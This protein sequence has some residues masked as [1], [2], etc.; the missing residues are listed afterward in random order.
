[1]QGTEFFSRLFLTPI[2]PYVE[3][4]PIY[5]HPS[6][7]LQSYTPVSDCTL[8]NAASS[9]NS[10]YSNKK[11]N[12]SLMY[13]N[14]IP[15]SILD[16]DFQCFAGSSNDTPLHLPALDVSEPDLID[17]LA[18]SIAQERTPW[19]QTFQQTCHFKT[20]Q[21]STNLSL[22]SN[23]TPSTSPDIGPSVQDS[24][25]ASRKKSKK[26]EKPVS[27]RQ[28]SASVERDPL[29]NSRPRRYSCIHV[30]CGMEFLSSGHLVRHHRIHTQER[31]FKCSIP[32]CEMTF[33]RS[34][35]AIKHSR[36]HVKK[37]QIAG[38]EIPPELLS[39]RV[40]FSAAALT[41]GASTESYQQRQYRRRK[42]T[43]GSSQ[44][45]TEPS[46]VISASTSVSDQSP[47]TCTDEIR[48][49]PS[50]FPRQDLSS[51]S[52]TSLKTP[53]RCFPMIGSSS[54]HAFTPDNLS[55]SDLQL[56][57]VH[58]QQLSDSAAMW[59]Y[60]NNFSAPPAHLLQ[61][62]S[63]DMMMGCREHLS[64]PQP[65][66]NIQFQPQYLPNG[67]LANPCSGFTHYN[68]QFLRPPANSMFQNSTKKVVQPQRCYQ[69]PISQESHSSP[70]VFSGCDIDAMSPE[71]VGDFWDGSNIL[72][73]AC[74][75]FEGAPQ[76][77]PQE[78][79]QVFHQEFMPNLERCSSSDSSLSETFPMLNE[80]DLGILL[81]ESDFLLNQG[82]S[83]LSDILL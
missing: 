18:Q 41:P 53:I 54:S 73:N 28:Q 4:A 35:T 40:T 3:S 33:A 58:L 77:F 17:A 78:R 51:Q 76:P 62:L 30:G 19:S 56:D 39:P 13:S 37:L 60:Y 20:P 46:I 82:H 11:E 64:L 15:A 68:P 52:E 75:S 63:P 22:S 32:T 47:Q 57:P 70:D 74:A 24:L 36:G 67:F 2:L 6:M 25:D 48:P 31:P 14:S 69:D 44:V 45:K 29:T 9:A 38:H 66:Q 81:E 61:N 42:P 59:D 10:A 23:Q 83:L 1:M 71:N 5:N 50:T 79:G 65:Q 26:L 72:A 49:L 8:L 55:M 34:D 12:A 16:T 43:S 27:N 80:T 7:S 21:P